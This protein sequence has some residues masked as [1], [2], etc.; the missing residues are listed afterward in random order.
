MQQKLDEIDLQL[1]HLLQIAPRASWA[2]LAPILGL[3]PSALAARWRR[4]ERSGTAWLTV[5]ADQAVTGHVSAIVRVE[6][7]PGTRAAVREACI[8]DPRIVGIDEASSGSE[9][10]LTTMVS[11]LHELSDHLDDVESWS[12]VRRLRASV[13]H[14]VLR[15]GSNWRLGHLD[16]EQTAA[17]AALSRI[18]STPVVTSPLAAPPHATPAGGAPTGSMPLLMPPMPP[19]AGALAALLTRDARMPIAD[20]ARGL[21]GGATP[22]TTRRHLDRLVASGAL[23]FR[24]DLAH[25]A[26]DWPVTSAWFV[27]VPPAELTR[28]IALLSSLTQLRLLL[29]ITGEVNLV[30]SVFGRSVAGVSA[31]EEALGRRLPWLEQVESM[32]LLR[33]V[34]RMGWVLDDRGRRTDRLVVPTVVERLGRVSG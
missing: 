18:P 28:T 7:R 29:G 34:K 30:F 8:D 12:G 27:R 3:S 2:G 23:A 4:L 6:C 33:S 16:A 11:D 25:D 19:D 21:G 31:F 15:A 14:D 26:A 1:V 32:L 20:L 10:L 9:L 24:C 22:A 17:A 13:V 5:H